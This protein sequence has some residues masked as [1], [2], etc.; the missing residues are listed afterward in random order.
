VVI[1]IEKCRIILVFKVLY[2]MDKMFVIY[3]G[4]YYPF[5]NY[6]NCLLFSELIYW[7]FNLMYRSYIE[8]LFY[9]IIIGFHFYHDNHKRFDNKFL[10]NYSKHQSCRCSILGSQS[11]WV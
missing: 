6:C 1:D 4:F 2:F 5:L 11:K 9:R 10:I 8:I 7:S 3:M